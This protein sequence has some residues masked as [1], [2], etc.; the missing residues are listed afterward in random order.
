MN[1]P[2]TIRLGVNATG[3]VVFEEI[4]HT[5]V[6]QGHCSAC[7]GPT[8]RQ[9]TFNRTVNP[10]NRRADGTI[11]TANEV[12]EDVLALARAWHPNHDHQNCPEIR[13]ERVL[14]RR[15]GRL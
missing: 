10:T 1:T 3:R 15:G 8:N 4:K 6:R 11:K 7:G 9:R 14:R 2:R 12:R 13:M 5:E